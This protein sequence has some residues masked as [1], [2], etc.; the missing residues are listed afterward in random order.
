MLSR[1]G[2]WLEVVPH[3]SHNSRTRGK[4]WLGHG[5]PSLQPPKG[6]VQA[7]GPRPHPE[8]EAHRP[9]W[10]RSRLSKE[11]QRTCRG[12]SGPRRSAC[13]SLCRRRS[14]R[15]PGLFPERQST[16]TRVTH[17]GPK[18]ISAG[19]TTPVKTFLWPRLEMNSYKV[20]GYEKI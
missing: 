5:P 7:G 14:G 19:E 6:S 12:G 17:Y 9:L 11:S 2:K 3:V 1:L 20:K 18:C 13:S 10:P 15:S 8:R 16:E 4:S